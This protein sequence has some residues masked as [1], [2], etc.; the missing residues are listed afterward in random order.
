MAPSRISPP[1]ERNLID[2]LTPKK[3][4]TWNQNGYLILP[5]ALSQ[6]EVGELLSESHSMLQD[7]YLDDHPMTRFSTG[8][9]SDHVGDD[10]FLTS[11]DKIRFFF[12]PDALDA[13]GNLVVPKERAVNKIGHALH[14]LDPEFRRVT[15]ENPRVRQ[16]VKDLDR[17][18]DPRALQ[19][20]LICKNPRIGASVPI[21]DD[22][23]FLY[24]EPPSAVG[25]WIALE[26]ATPTNGALSFLPGSH[27]RNKVRNR[28]V[29]AE[30]GGTTFESVPGV[31]GEAPDWA[32]EPGWVEKPVKAG[33]LVLIDGLVIH[34]SE[35]NLSEKSRL[36]CAWAGNPGK[37]THTD[38]FHIIDGAATFDAKNWLQPSPNMPF[39]PLSGP[40]ATQ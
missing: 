31:E 10:Y 20:M 9:N 29:R 24:T 4:E 6:A 14:E 13:Q 34:R 36:I 35:R 15:L 21:H 28:F 22:S 5:A 2:G 37:L 33:D 19:S 11:G 3:L 8:E 27:K 23:T 16:I 40:I 18:R 39:S 12:E 38:T 32:N 7:F 26:D 17:H 25:I 30:G 1:P